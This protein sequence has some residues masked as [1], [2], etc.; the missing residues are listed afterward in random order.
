MSKSNIIKLFN[1]LSVRHNSWTTFSDF[2]E[3]ASISI[4]NS[5]NIINIEK[6]ENRYKEVMRKYNDREIEIFPKIL[7]E[8]IISMEEEPGDVLGELFMELELGNKWKGQFFTPFSICKLSAEIIFDDSIIKEKGFITLNEPACGGGAMI[9]AFYQVMKNRGYNP[10][11]Q[12]KV[13]CQDLDV[14]SV[15]MSYIQ[16]SLLGIPAVV[17]HGNTL[18][19]EMYEE[20]KTP[21]WILGGWEFK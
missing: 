1:E 10:R 13:I 9:I 5:L 16:L 7:G 4:R 2:L 11:T 19:L 21:M 20:W 17:Y 15:Y 6:Y 3:V 8:L 18:S 12:L 14:K